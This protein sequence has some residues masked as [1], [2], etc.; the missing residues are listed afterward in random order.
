MHLANGGGPGG[1]LPT[2]GYLSGT[3]AVARWGRHVR[4]LDR[5]TG[6]WPAWFLLNTMMC[7]TLVSL[8]GG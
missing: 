6:A 5:N 3:A 2:D 8:R 7:M 4:L 1:R